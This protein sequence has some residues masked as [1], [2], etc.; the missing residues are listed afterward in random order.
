M[1]ESKL[2]AALREKAIRELVV[3]KTTEVQP[4]IRR[5]DSPP[6]EPASPASMQ[7][8]APHLLPAV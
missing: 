3:S 1:A 4:Q 7:S 2:E 6:G 8:S 5:R